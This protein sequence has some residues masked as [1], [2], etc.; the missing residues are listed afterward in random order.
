MQITSVGW[1]DRPST[2]KDHYS[3]GKFWLGFLLDH[4]N[5][6]L[7]AFWIFKSPL[8][9]ST[10]NDFREWFL[11]RMAEP[12]AAWAERVKFPWKPCE[13]QT[14]GTSQWEI[15][16]TYGTYERGRGGLEEKF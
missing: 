2:Q 4:K 13:S 3:A 9:L 16:E 6:K 1:K 10:I 12:T 14:P 11:K 15:V 8:N 5:D 7:T